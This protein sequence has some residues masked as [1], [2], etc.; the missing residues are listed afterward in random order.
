MGSD[1]IYYFNRY[2]GK[3]E[4]ERV[5]GESWLRWA[6]E[7]RPGRLAT[8]LL[9]KRHW[10]SHWYGWRMRGARSR[11]L[12]MPFVRDYGIDVRES[13]RHPEK[14]DCF[15]A[16]FCRR[17]KPEMRPIC[18]DKD[19]A[20]FPADGRHRIAGAGLHDAG[21]EVKGERFDLERLLG[22]RDLARLFQNGTLI[23]SRLCPIDYHRFHFPVSGKPIR[24]ERVN[25]PLFSVNPLALKLRP[26]ILV[27]NKR[28]LSVLETER[29]GFVVMVEVGATFVGTIAQTFEMGK[30]VRRGEE[31]G[32]FSFGGSA[33]VTLFEAG[34]VDWDD[35]LKEHSAKG[36]EVYARMGDRMGRMGEGG[37]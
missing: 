28:E 20:V 3:V 21:I 11:R 14:Y 31:K 32:H 15:D 33:I 6:Y 25:G 34:R 1:P 36:L 29:F 27:E 37:S 22:H 23:T 8:T 5:Y 7:T 10:F 30:S 2:T 9:V 26:G 16:F 24:R 35:D 19:T 17:L 18:G 13:Q 4:Q 12:I